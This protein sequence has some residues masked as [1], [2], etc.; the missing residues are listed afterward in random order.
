MKQIKIMLSAI[1]I[2]GLVAGILAFK[3]AKAGSVTF[4]RCDDTQIPSTCIQV[5]FQHATFTVNGN[6]IATFNN[7]SKTID[8]EQV[9]CNAQGCVNVL[10]I[11]QAD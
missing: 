2:L 3:K 1:A 8:A 4:Y 9:G 10:K 7:A 11:Y 6:L 5:S